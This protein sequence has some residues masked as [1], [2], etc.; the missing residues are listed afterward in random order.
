MEL[1]NLKKYINGIMSLFQ[2]RRIGQGTK[3]PNIRFWIHQETNHNNIE[4]SKYWF[5]LDVLLLNGYLVLEDKSQDF[6][7]LSENG[8]DYI[9]GDGELNL[10]VSLY[11]LLYVKDRLEKEDELY[12]K[13]WTI[14]GQEEKAL[15]YVNGPTFYN[16]IYP[17]IK[18]AHPSYSLY[19]Q[20]LRDS[21]KSTSRVSYYRELFKKLPKEAYKGF[22][23]A[24]SEMINEEL[25]S[26]ENSARDPWA[27]P[28]A[29]TTNPVGEEHVSQEDLQQPEEG[30]EQLVSS[31]C[32]KRVFIS[33]AHD[34]NKTK[35][36]KLAHQLKSDGFKVIID[37]D[38]PLG[39]NLIAFMND[40]SNVDRVLVIL[41]PAYKKKAEMNEGGAGYESG[42]INA[43]IYKKQDT[44]K[45]IPV[46]FEG[47][48]ATSAPSFLQTRL[49]LD[50]SNEKDWEVNYKKLV[51][52]LKL[53]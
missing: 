17:F 3:L 9:N 5:T 40:L 21:K 47:S 22:F 36:L 13:L 2:D 26:E 39:S 1:D 41:T 11:D 31:N 28:S 6:V 48:F 35:V 25:Q 20:S 33:Y 29:T 18:G 27:E 7:F 15:L 53:H 49:G 8:Y 43:E 51:E 4:S 32:S 52:D 42:I 34:N 45:F 12:E 44:N 30:S 38:L 50:L 46:L 24:L 14:I 23:D 10:K 16:S 19:M 37:H